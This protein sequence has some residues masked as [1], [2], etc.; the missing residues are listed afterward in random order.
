MAF[1]NNLQEYFVQWRSSYLK[2][3]DYYAGAYQS[4]EDLLRSC[5]SIKDQLNVA[6]VSALVGNPRHFPQL[7]FSQSGMAATD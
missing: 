6:F 1:T 3:I 4:F 5:I 7:M 2:A